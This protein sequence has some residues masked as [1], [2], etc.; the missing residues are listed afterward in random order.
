MLTYIL[1]LTVPKL[2]QIIGGEGAHRGEARVHQL[3][4]TFSP[5]YHNLN[6]WISRSRSVSSRSGVSGGLNLL[7]FGR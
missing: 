6:L 2:L 7:H 4:Q 5:A 3:R 1:S